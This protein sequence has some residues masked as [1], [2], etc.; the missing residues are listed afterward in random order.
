MTKNLL[1][2]GTRGSPLAQAQA[3][4]TARALEKA[5]ENLC[6]E[7]KIIRTTGDKNQTASLPAI[8]GKG[9]FTLEIEQ[10]LLR[11]EIDFAVHSLKDL[12]PDSPEGLCLG[13]VPKRATADDVCVLRAGFSPSENAREYSHSEK[14]RWN[15]L[16]KGARIGTSSLR[17]RAQLLCFRSDLAISE[18]RG[19]IDT[20]LQ[21]LDSGAFDAIVLAGAGLHRLEIVREENTVF[22]FDSDFLPAPGQGALALEC[23]RDD[24]RVLALLSAI[25]DAATLLEIKAERALMRALGAG[26]S[27]PLGARATV[28]QEN[29]MALRAAV[30]SPDGT[31]RFFAEDFSA[32][33]NAESLG[34]RVA[35]KL[36]QDGAAAAWKEI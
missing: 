33:E 10:A 23:R 32:S 13:A 35:R 18:I 29:R 14:S 24:A 17:R 11:G 3:R 30:L 16:P 9:V 36:L 27:T 2:M 22:P 26:C 20:R 8:G 12:P 34:E 4:Q 21:K 19:N 28:S 15:F 5:N 31:Q 6:V 25:E 7:E 1:V